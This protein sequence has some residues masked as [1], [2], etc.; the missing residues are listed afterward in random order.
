MRSLLAAET[1][2]FHAAK[3]HVWVRCAKRIDADH[4]G[5]EMIAGQLR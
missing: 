5:I 1:G 2:V 3:R 4:A